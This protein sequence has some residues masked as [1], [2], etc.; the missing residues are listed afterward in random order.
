MTIR[1][2]SWI[3]TILPVGSVAMGIWITSL[4][5]HSLSNVI[6]VNR[7]ATPLKIVYLGITDAVPPASLRYS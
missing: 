2:A 3:R 5:T 4:A 1:M 6:V 7:G